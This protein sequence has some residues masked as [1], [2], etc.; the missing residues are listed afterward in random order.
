MKLW[1]KVAL[2][3]LLG[4][5]VGYLIGQAGVL[6]GFGIDG[7]ALLTDYV[8]PVG[9]IFINLIR[10]VV[11]PLIFF[12][13]IAGVTSMSDLGAFRRVGLKAVAAFF[14][15]CAFAVTIGLVCGTVFRPGEGAD[16]AALSAKA[17]VPAAPAGST[18]VVGMIVGMVPTNALKAMA[19]DHILQVVVFAVFVAVAL[20][21]Q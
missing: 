20:N 16:R 12:S 4:V 5:A 19:E 21:L 8:L 15:T 3:L 7:P 13:L 6:R 1:Q 11:V 9:T 10:M 14:L 2:G 17:N 18:N